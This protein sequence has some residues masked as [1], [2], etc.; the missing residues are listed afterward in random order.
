MNF[1]STNIKYLRI[2]HNLSQCELA[3][4]VGLKRGN[5]ASYEK[6]IAEPKLLNLSKLANFFQIS[7]S[8]FISHDLSKGEPIIEE[9]QDNLQ[10]IVVDEELERI[11]AECKEFEN[12]INGMKCYHN[13]RM[14][15]IKEHTDDIKLISAEVERLLSV[16]KCLIE[17]HQYLIRKIDNNN[18][19]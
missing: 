11:V 3:D 5:I 10:R 7:I 4:K 6:C 14:N 9:K 16:A 1:V 17:S 8:A 19:C 2:R 12:I 13:F 15:Q 18:N